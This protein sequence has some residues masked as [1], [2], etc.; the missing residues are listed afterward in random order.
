MQQK[1]F[2]DPFYAT[3]NLFTVEERIFDQ[4]GLT[5]KGD[6]FFYIAS[7]SCMLY[8]KDSSNLIIETF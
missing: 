6:Y 3:K 2:R 8:V 5:C 4:S 7:S 1:I